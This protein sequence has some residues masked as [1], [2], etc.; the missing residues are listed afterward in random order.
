[1]AKKAGEAK[2][3]GQSGWLGSDS[4]KHSCTL[5]SAHSIELGTHSSTAHLG[6]RSAASSSAS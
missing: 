6:V 5:A 2:T 3:M 4:T 1:M